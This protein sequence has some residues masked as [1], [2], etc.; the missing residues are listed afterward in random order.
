M[1]KNINS[2]NLYNKISIE[3]W[4]RIADCVQHFNISDGNYKEFKAN[5]E[6]LQNFL[7]G[8]EANLSANRSY[9]QYFFEIGLATLVQSIYNIKSKD[10][11]K[12]HFLEQIYT[13]SDLGIKNIQFEGETS[14]SI[15]SL[16]D[17]LVA[18]DYDKR[19][20]F[21]LQK[22]FTDGSFHVEKQDHFANVFQMMD[23]EDVN[24]LLDIK[25]L[26]SKEGNLTIKFL[27]EADAVLINFDGVFPS[28]QEIMEIQFP[29]LGIGSSISEWQITNENRVR[30]HFETHTKRKI[31]LPDEN[32]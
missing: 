32:N 1:K 13:L 27:K 15:V 20:V 16:G 19:N 26:F 30:Q 14:Q 5:L 31:Y 25:L 3:T 11:K 29:N 6:M 18:N 22:I 8:T 4:L 10:N 24:Y 12:E 28:K 17:I 7:I 9:A 2:V 23:I 21:L